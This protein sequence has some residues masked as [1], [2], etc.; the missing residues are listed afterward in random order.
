M[1]L[2]IGSN[3]PVV[4]KWQQTMLRR[5]ASYAKAADGGPLR[6]DGYFGKD[7]LAVHQEWQRRVHRLVTDN[8]SDDEL[9]ILGVTKPKPVF[10]T[11]EGHLSDMFRGPVADTANQL[12]AEGLC[13]HQPTGYNNGAIPFDNPSGVR[14]LA[15]LVGSTTL[16]DGAGNTVPFP[17][18]TPIA[19]GGFS[20]GGIVL[21]DFWV[22]YLL[23]GKPLE[24]RAKDVKAVLTYGNPCRQTDSIAPWARA[25]AP[26]TGTNGLDP[27]RRFGINGF[28][29]KP[30]YWMDVYRGGDIF[31][32]NT[33]DKAGEVKAAIYQA[34]ARGDVFSNP[35]SLATQIADLFLAPFDEVLGMVM[36]IISGIG[37]L[38][39]G[40]GAPHYAPYDITGGVDWMR[41]QLAQ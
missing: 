12:Q 30:D 41:R 17:A 5:F 26:K 1:S 29:T 22:D 10:L 6:A 9:L 27:Y 13:F 35:Y 38:A 40:Q 33:P 16:R 21:F 7:D 11:V 14:A 34:V 24:W 8:V 3:D 28:P 20:Q 25:W 36:A 18:G 2:K 37:F 32:E 39:D 19:L 15:E 31:A 23:P 4:L